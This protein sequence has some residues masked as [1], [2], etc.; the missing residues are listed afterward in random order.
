[1]AYKYFFILL[2]SILYKF[3][4][5]RSPFWKQFWRKI[6]LLMLAFF[7][8][9]SSRTTVV[10]A[11]YNQVSEHFPTN[12]ISKKRYGVFVLLS[13]FIF[14]VYHTQRYI[15]NFSLFIRSLEAVPK[16]WIIHD[17]ILSWFIHAFWLVPS[18]GLLEDRPET[19][20][21]LTVLKFLVT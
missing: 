21:P 12:T 3:W 11:I 13:L 17:H 18:Y 14:L 7:V 8:D 5:V 6:T 15:D 19:T 20:S 9:N 1:M 10:Y 2:H 4:Y 16:A